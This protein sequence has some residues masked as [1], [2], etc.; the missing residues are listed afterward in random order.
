VQGQPVI[1]E[2]LEACTGE[3]GGQGG[4]SIA[5]V[6]GKG[7]ASARRFNGGT[8]QRQIFSLMQQGA[9]TGGQGEEPC[10]SHLRRI[11]RING[12]GFPVLDQAADAIGQMHEDLTVTDQIAILRNGLV[13]DGIGQ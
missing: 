9:D 6:T 4:F 7:N 10:S 11:A 3:A 8:V 13:G 2:Q 5:G 1:G 12:H